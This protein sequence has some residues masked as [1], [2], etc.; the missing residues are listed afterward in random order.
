MYTPEGA[1][2]QAGRSESLASRLILPAISLKEA[3]NAA[4][5]ASGTTISGR[6]SMQTASQASDW[7][8]TQS[9]LEGGSAQTDGDVDFPGMISSL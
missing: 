6:N 3:L 5:A 8:C 9:A 4:L 7:Q 1:T 2:S